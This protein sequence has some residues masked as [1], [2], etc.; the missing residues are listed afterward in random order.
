MA[1]IAWQFDMLCWH[2]KSVHGEAIM[3]YA[4]KIVGNEVC[5]M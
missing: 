3:T 4:G 5:G 2:L 1:L